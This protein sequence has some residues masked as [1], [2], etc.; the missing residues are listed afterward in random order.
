M[1]RGEDVRAAADVPYRLLE[2]V[3]SLDGGDAA[4]GNMLIQGDN[5]DALKALLPYYKG[6]VKCIYIDPPFNTGEAFENYD[7][8]LEH[9]VWLG[10]MY[11]RL[12]LLREFL[13]DDGTLIVHL[14]ANEIAYAT[15]ILDEIM[16]RKNRTYFVTFKQSAP[17][18]HKTINPGLVTTANYIVIY[19]K[20]KNEWKPGRS[21]A[22]RPRDKRYSSFIE[23][24]DEDMQ[25]WRLITV[26][27]AFCKHFDFRTLGEA[28]KVLGQ[29]FESKIERFVLDHADRVVQPVRPDTSQ[30]A[31]ETQEI[32]ELSER[33]PSDTFLIKRDDKLPIV[34]RGGQRWLFYSSKLRM[35]DG[36]YTTGE[37]LSNIWDDLLSNNIHNEGDVRFPKGKKPEALIRRIL[38]LFSV[39]GDLVLDSFLG[40]GTTAAV[41]HKMGRRWI[42]IEMGEHAVTHCK[43]RLDK[44][45]AGEQGG[46]SEAV[47]WAGGGGYRFYRLGA[48]VFDSE[49]H[50]ADGIAFRTLAAHVW[51][52][53]TGTP[54]IGTADTP[55]LGVHDGIAYALLYNGILG[56]R[57]VS[58][59]NVLTA[60]L[61]AR[62]REESGWHGPITVYGE[63]SKLGAARLAEAGVTFKQ[64]PYDV[65]AR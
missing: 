42:G 41:A 57:S 55:V 64:T 10:L 37:A 2:T 30:V 17:K 52:S 32:I 15:V 45:I 20:N 23:N 48:A 53:E 18:G 6:A 1:T 19:A 11:P 50:I 47:G 38:E 12:A 46:V 39:R 60:A 49:G 31:K 26:N 24:F 9:S 33:N 59:G 35:I 25:D 62:L 54:F 3:P 14:D 22:A 44:V 29:G 43:P 36:R 63:W 13:A 4:T 8:N 34:L 21:Y 27:K 5:L 56:D 65:R 51:F 61:L 16:G 7:D 58:G 28:K 40:S